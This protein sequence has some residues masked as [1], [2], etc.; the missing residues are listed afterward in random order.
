MTGNNATAQ[1]SLHPQLER[2]TVAVGDLKLSR[3]LLINDANYPWLL[4]VPRRPGAVE[5]IDLSDTEQVE[6]MGEIAHASRVMKAMT[7]CTKINVAALGNVVPQLHVHVIARGRSD[8][9]WPKPVWGAVPPRAYGETALT[10]MLAD[11]RER[12]Q[13]QTA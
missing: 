12:L 11:L 3:V 13:L 5:I 6:L 4:L 7:G 9:A 10:S 8:P 1:W 2:D